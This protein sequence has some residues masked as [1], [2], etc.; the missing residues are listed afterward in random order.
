MNSL[1]TF[2]IEYEM[3]ITWSKAKQ[4]I[5]RRTIKP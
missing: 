3:D 1:E 2:V 5:K 4:N